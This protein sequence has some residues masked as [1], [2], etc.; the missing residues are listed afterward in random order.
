MNLTQ[1]PGKECKGGEFIQ[2][3]RDSR[4]A[5]KMLIFFSENT[6]KFNFNF[7]CHFFILARLSSET[8]K[9]LQNLCLFKAT[10]F[11]H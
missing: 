2:K 4:K 11:F 8:G 9:I 7:F 3:N 6:N 5:I 1:L 10:Q